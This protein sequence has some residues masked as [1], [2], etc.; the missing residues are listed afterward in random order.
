VK[1]QATL[2]RK[3]INWAKVATKHALS[4]HALFGP[5]TLPRV[6]RCPGSVRLAIENDAKN[7]ETEYSIEGTRSHALAADALIEDLDLDE[8][9]DTYFHFRHAGKLESFIVE[10][11]R[12][13]FLQKYVD[14][15]RDRPGTHFVETQASLEMFIPL[16]KQFGT[17]D[18]VA[19]Y[20]R[21]LDVTDLKYGEGEIV[22]AMLNEQLMAYA[23]AFYIEWKDLFPI[24]HVVLR[25]C[26]PRLGHYDEWECS[27]DRLLEF[28]EELRAVVDEAMGP[29][30]RVI[31]GEE[32]CK[33]CP[34]GGQCSVQT[35]ATQALIRGDFDSFDEPDK[36][37]PR[38]MTNDELARAIAQK[39]F[40]KKWMSQ[41]TVRAMERINAGLDVG[42]L[43]LVETNTHRQFKSHLQ[44]KKFLIEECGLPRNL[45]VEEKLTSP[46]QAEK[47]LSKEQREEL[48]DLV[49][50]PPGNPTLAPASDKR[51]SFKMDI[52]EFDGFDEEND[53]D[54]L[55]D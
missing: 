12:G 4:G 29:N 49:W 39:P 38:A 19:I 42:G 53:D 41:I 5:S 18:F 52:S 48:S 6:F 26:Q 36:G 27:I 51:K 17:S 55:S 24:D 54:D 45:V 1:V 15:C 22:Y 7:R 11:D 46:A 25:I 32:Q 3:K 28:G 44:A 10:A 16:P 21:T 23:L 43:K 40:I 31:P 50:K 30:P 13:A 35:A 14:E 33:F 37:E 34:M 2:G 20:G 8:Y 47:L 9:V